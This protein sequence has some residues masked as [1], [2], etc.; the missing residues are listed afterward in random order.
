MEVDELGG[1]IDSAVADSL[2]DK[3]L[4]ELLDETSPETQSS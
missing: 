3:T 2:G 1:L 4:A